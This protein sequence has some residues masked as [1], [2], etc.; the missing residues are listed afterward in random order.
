MLKAGLLMAAVTVAVVESYKW[1]SPDPAD[2]TVKLLAQISQQ[3]VNISNGIP[4]E[5]ISE[6]SQ[7]FQ[8]TTSSIIV[9]VSWFFSGIA[10]L[11]C[12]LFATLIQHQARRY[13]VL[14]QRPG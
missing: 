7:P 11:G 13:Q 6:N 12:S 14:T 2:E 10:A 3:L 4:L 8:P 5:S 1:L 9:N